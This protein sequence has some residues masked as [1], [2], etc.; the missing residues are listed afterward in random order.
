MGLT[1]RLV[2]QAWGAA[3]QQPGGL[4]GQK[5][6]HR[7]NRFPQFTRPTVGPI[8]RLVFQAWG[9]AGQQ[10]GGLAGQEVFNSFPASFPHIPG[11]LWALL[12]D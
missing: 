12:E 9:A 4:A 3:G 2:L 10:P 8:R 11:Q 5:V 1:R 6:F 7:F